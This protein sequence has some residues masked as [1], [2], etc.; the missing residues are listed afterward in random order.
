MI[1]KFYVRKNEEEE[2]TTVD[3]WSKHHRNMV[4]QLRPICPE[5]LEEEENCRDFCDKVEECDAYKSIYS[6]FAPAYI[7]CMCNDNDNLSDETG[8]RERCYLGKRGHDLLEKV[9]SQLKNDPELLSVVA[10]NLKIE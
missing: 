9:N 1:T 8:H 2:K 6:F 3:T 10:R 7:V 4:Q 5:G